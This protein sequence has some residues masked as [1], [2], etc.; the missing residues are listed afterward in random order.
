M[1]EG[2]QKGIQQGLAALVNSLKMVLPDLDAVCRAVVQNE[3]YKDV[4]RDEIVRHY[5]SKQ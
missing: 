1:Q 5:G 4:S 3:I 2:M